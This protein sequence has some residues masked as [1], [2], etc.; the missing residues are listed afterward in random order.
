MP[1]PVTPMS[2][3]MVPIETIG[4]WTYWGPARKATLADI[5]ALL[6]EWGGEV[7]EVV[8]VNASYGR[9]SKVIQSDLVFV[10]MDHEIAIDLPP[11]RYLVVPLDVLA[12]RTPTSQDVNQCQ[13]DRQTLD[14]DTFDVAPLSEWCPR[15]GVIFPLD[16]LAADTGKEQ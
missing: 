7:V 1:D 9:A 4:E 6:R 15:C 5:L 16:V 14:S 10:D 3:L 13:H 11:G 12:G 2:D 8:E